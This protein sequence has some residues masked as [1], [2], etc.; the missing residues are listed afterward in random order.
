VTGYERAS[1][2]LFEKDSEN[3]K[4][5]RFDWIRGYHTGGPPT[6]VGMMVPLEQTGFTANSEEGIGVD[7][8]VRY[9]E[10]L[11]GTIT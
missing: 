1:P 10:E 3:P 2:L 4:K 9:E 8:P 5:K 11:R 7:W 6:D